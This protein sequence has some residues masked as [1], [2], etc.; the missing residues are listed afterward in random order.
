MRNTEL[1]KNC[2]KI[3]RK[4]KDVQDTKTYNYQYTI[5]KN[6]VNVG[7]D[8]N[9]EFI[10]I[11]VQ[12]ADYKLQRDLYNWATFSEDEINDMIDKMTETIKTLQNDS[13]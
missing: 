3:I 5:W 1:V 12:T 2:F 7:F 11:Y 13:K 8:F 10:H 9:Q 4:E 6:N